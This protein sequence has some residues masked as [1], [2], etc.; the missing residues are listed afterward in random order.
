MS[1]TP[2]TPATLKLAS[3]AFHHEGRIPLRHTADGEDLSPPLSWSAPPEATRS[4]ALI[5]DDP[6]APMGVWVHWVLYDLSPST[7]SLAE[8]IPTDRELE[9]GARQG[10]NDFGRIGYGGPSP[11]KG[12]AHRYCFKLYA[13]DT[14]LPLPEDA[15]KQQV[16][17]AMEGHILAMGQIVAM[18][19]RD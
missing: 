2:A 3:R 11:P 15:G 14:K 18:Y 13:L 5:C 17:A 12:P 16:E 10:K 9:G 4:L 1:A 8:G 6:D 19:G 7:T